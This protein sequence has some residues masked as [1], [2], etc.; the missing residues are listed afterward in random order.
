[1]KNNLIKCVPMWDKVKPGTKFVAYIEGI[2]CEGRIQKEDSSI[3][4][5]Q[6]AK[7]GCG[8]LDRLG[9]RH[10]WTINDGTEEN[11]SNNRVEILSLE[12]DP[13]F[14]APPTVE[15]GDGYKVTFEV[16]YINV[17]CQQITNEQVIQV[18]A[19]LKWK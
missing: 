1:M 9:Y 4:L 11:L 7:E 18:V 15:V 3:Y 17:G 8:C 16:G 19:N 5:C 13:E 14:V 6:D 12:E 10:S 2:R